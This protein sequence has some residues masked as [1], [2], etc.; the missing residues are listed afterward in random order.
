MTRV[1]AQ[2]AARAKYGEMGAI[3][4]DELL[5]RLVWCIGQ[6]DRTVGRGKTWE[7]ALQR[8]RPAKPAAK[9]EE[10]PSEAAK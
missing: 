4:S 10:A 1:E 7:I 2:D 3:S 8:S 6:F 9:R 5:P